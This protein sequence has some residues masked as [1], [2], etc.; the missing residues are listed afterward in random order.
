MHEALGLTHRFLS[1]LPVMMF[2]FWNEISPCLLKMITLVRRVHK[3]SCSESLSLGVTRRAE[4]VGFRW[5]AGFEGVG[6]GV[7]MWNSSTMEG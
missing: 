2:R 7:R 4:G 6:V 3:G 5:H 1:R